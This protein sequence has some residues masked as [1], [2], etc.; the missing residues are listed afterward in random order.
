MRHLRRKCQISELLMNLL[1]SGL[2]MILRTELNLIELT[3]RTELNLRIEL[4]LKKNLIEL[5]LKI[6]LI[7]LKMPLK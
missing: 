2:K 7:E 6:L 1:M 3:L 4:I 5:S